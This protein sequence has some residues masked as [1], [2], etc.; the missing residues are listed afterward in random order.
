MSQ[1]GFGFSLGF[2]TVHCCGHALTLDGSLNYLTKPQSC[3]IT[4]LWS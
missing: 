2:N 1:Q 4:I 3:H